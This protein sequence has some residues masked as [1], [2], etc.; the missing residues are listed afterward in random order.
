MFKKKLLPFFDS[1]Y[2]GYASGSLEKD[3]YAVR[4]FEKKRYGNV[5]CTII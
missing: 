4:L 5:N 1:A 2:Q 3:S